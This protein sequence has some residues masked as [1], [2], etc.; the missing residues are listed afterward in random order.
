MALVRL[1][2]A[3]LPVDALV[4]PLHRL[5]LLHMLTTRP[6][7][8]LPRLALLRCLSAALLVRVTV[9]IVTTLGSLDIIYD[10]AKNVGP[11]GFKAAHSLPDRFLT[12]ILRV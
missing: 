4:V 3:L 7:A 1:T 6:E 2:S 12:G 11:N 8:A 5:C 9:L 10:R